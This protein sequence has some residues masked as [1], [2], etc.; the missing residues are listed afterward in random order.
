[1]ALKYKAKIPW[2]KIALVVMAIVFVVVV[3]GFAFPAA[4][5][6]LIGLA[7]GAGAALANFFIYQPS[8]ITVVVVIVIVSALFILVTQRKYFFKQRM[9][10]TGAAA[11]VVRQDGLMQNPNAFAAAPPS[12]PIVNTDKVEVST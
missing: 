3:I 1:M 5:A 7:V 11:P 4:G 9:P 10:P 6:Y 8:W 12:T 2:L